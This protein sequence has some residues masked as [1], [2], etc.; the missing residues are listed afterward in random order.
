MRPMNFEVTLTEFEGVGR[1]SS[2]AL[3]KKMKKNR[4]AAKA[5]AMKKARR[6]SIDSAVAPVPSSRLQRQREGR[7]R[8]CVVGASSLGQ[9]LGHEILSRQHGHKTRSE[10]PSRQGPAGNLGGVRPSPQ[11]AFGSLDGP[12]VLVRS[13][14]VGSEDFRLGGRALSIESSGAVA[15][16]LGRSSCPAPNDTGGSCFRILSGTVVSRN[17]AEAGCAEDSRRWRQLANHNPSPVIGPNSPI[18][19]WLKLVGDDDSSTVPSEA[20]AVAAR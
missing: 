20:R 19:D 12:N 17:A 5:R 3:A 4:T 14:R 9:S 6:T 1:P 11:L 16:L 18:A 15:Q 10:S 2:E 8:V 13:A 7:P